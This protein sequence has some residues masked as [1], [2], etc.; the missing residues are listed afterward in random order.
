MIVKTIY[1]KNKKCFWR[2]ISMMSSSLFCIAKVARQ[3]GSDH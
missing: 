1:Q 3:F 2:Y